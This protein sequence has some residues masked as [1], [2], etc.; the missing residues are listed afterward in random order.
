MNIYVSKLPGPRLTL[1][2]AEIIF[3]I[4]LGGCPLSKDLQGVSSLK[5]KITNLCI[6]IHSISSPLIKCGI[7]VISEVATA[8]KRFD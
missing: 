2:T 5:P 3:C 1:L 7:Y 6:S 4:N 8:A